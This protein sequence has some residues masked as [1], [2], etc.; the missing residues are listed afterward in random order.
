M[1]KQGKEAGD[2]P[3]V[4][5]DV[6]DANLAISFMLDGPSNEASMAVRDGVVERL[7]ASLRTI[8]EAAA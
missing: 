7:R 1:S 2:Y 8:D 3:A 6:L 5:V 4:T